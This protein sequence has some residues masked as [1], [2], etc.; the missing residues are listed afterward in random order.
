MIRLRPPIGFARLDRY[1][2]REMWIPFVAGAF[3][4]ALMFQANS[5]IWLAKSFNLDNIPVEARIK[6]LLY[7]L[8]S[9]LKLTLPTGMALAAALSIGRMGRESEVTALRAAGVSVKRL[10]CPVI[11]FG[12][13]AGLLNFYI[14]DRMIPVYSKKAAQ[15]EAINA[16]AGLSRT[17]FKSNAFVQLNQYAV[18][19]GSVTRQKNDVLLIHDILLIEQSGSAVTL[20]FNA[21]AGTYDRGIWTFQN[22]HAYRVKG[23]EITPIEGDKIIVDQ[24]IDLE[25][26]F[27]AN[28][29][30]ILANNEDLPT[31]EL[32]KAAESARRTRM[33]D[34][35]QYEVEYYSRFAAIVACAVF[36]FTSAVFAIAFSRSGGFA[37][38]LVSFSVVVLYYNSY[39]ISVQVL[40]RQENVPTWLAA[41]LPN[42]LFGTLGLLWLRRV[43]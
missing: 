5:Y 3:I 32:L 1:V 7:T 24:S 6:W 11:I 23:T 41:W 34:P 9:Q 28:T 19:M 14:V 13:L 22:G 39:V 25:A 15:L 12:L 17:N 27:T 37:G 21:P 29:Q 10:M 4:V 43:E 42:I 16:V 18:R 38:L 33:S 40:G 30:G 8:P 2:M 31:T 36:A 26:F 35:R 20:I